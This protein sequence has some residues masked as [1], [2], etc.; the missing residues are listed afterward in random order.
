M[1]VKKGIEQKDLIGVF[2]IYAALGCAV[3][4]VNSK[5]VGILTSEDY[6]LDAVRDEIIKD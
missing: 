1:N 4:L 3:A 6:L 2:F 5:I